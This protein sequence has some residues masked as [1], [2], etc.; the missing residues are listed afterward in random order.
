MC[1]LVMSP[2]PRELTNHDV[3]ITNYVINF[4]CTIIPVVVLDSVL[5]FVITHTS[6]WFL[7]RELHQLVFIV[8]IQ[9][10]KFFI[11]KFYIN[12]NRCDMFVCMY[13]C[14]YVL[15]MCLHSSIP[16]DCLKMI[17][18]WEIHLLM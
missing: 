7:D 2:Y 4:H 18:F 13:I 8:Y 5:L 10:K 16:L 14:I 11:G 15:F 1:S 3:I 9:S 6:A 12:S 17:L